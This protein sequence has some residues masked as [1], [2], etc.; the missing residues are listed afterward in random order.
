[1]KRLIILNLILAINGCGE[2]QEDATQCSS[3]LATAEASPEPSSEPVSPKI[4]KEEKAAKDEKS[5]SKKS[6][7]VKVSSVVA[8]TFEA[9]VEPTP[10]A[11][12]DDPVVES[13][14][15]PTPDP[16]PVILAADDDFSSS[17]NLDRWTVVKPS[18]SSLATANGKLH[19]TEDSFD[20]AGSYIETKF[21]ITS[22]TFDTSADIEIVSSSVNNSNA[23][24]ATFFGT[25]PSCDFASLTLS[26]EGNG[27]NVLVGGICMNNFYYEAFRINNPGYIA[28]L[29][30]VRTATHLKWYADY[31]SGS[32]QLESYSLNDLT[33]VFRTNAYVQ[34]S[35]GNPTVGA[36]N[37]SVDN[38]TISGANYEY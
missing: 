38:F 36:T 15:E 25:N 9:P 26:R 13:D 35:F 30:V 37:V 14:P 3:D 8:T 23:T 22:A 32:F 7:E 31:G 27:S 18:G 2:C 5:K 19:W 16:E 33:A 29:R 6:E 21:D 1:M 24:F 17:L 28:E 10:T 12:P 20:S 11:T 34:I 4:D